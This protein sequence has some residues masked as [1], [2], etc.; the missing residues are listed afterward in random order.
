MIIV[1]VK[2]L[3]YEKFVKSSSVLPNDTGIYW[4]VK[5]NIAGRVR[6]FV[7]LQHVPLQGESRPRLSM[8]L[9]LNI[10]NPG[11]EIGKHLI[12]TISFLLFGVL[13]ML[14]FTLYYFQLQKVTFLVY[15]LQKHECFM[16]IFFLTDH[17]GNVNSG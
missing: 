14:A 15:C 17:Q 16:I 6:G 11:S 3:K 7:D 1:M 4:C 10:L 5:E 9:L 13:V 8:S 12:I 2:Y